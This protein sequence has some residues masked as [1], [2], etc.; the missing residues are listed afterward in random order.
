MPNSHQTVLS[1]D[2]FGLE[3]MS[4]ERDSLLEWESRET[5]TGV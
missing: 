5:P 4:E 1:L 3:P 2:Q